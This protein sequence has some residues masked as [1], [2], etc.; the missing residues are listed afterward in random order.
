MA[1]ILGCDYLAAIRKEVAKSLMRPK[2]EL[3]V[4]IFSTGVC[5]GGRYV[6]ILTGKMNRLLTSI[7]RTA[8][9]NS[10]KWAN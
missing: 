8:K 3:F 2:P 5:M 4:G 1:S 10:S 6:D 7:W 9:L